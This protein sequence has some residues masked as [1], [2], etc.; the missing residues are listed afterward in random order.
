M[1][2]VGYLYFA[3]HARA[4]GLSQPFEEV[5]GFR[6]ETVVGHIGRHAALSTVG[7]MV[8]GGK[9]KEA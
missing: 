8:R 9:L 5:R 1:P 6:V 3:A 7:L 4:W 2:Q